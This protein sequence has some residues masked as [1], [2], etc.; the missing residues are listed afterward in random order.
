MKIYG[1]CSVFTNNLLKLI[2]IITMTLDHIGL[3]MMLFLPNHDFYTLALVFRYIGRIAFPI[4]CFLIIEGMMHTRDKINYLLRITIMA[5]FMAICYAIV[6]HFSGYNIMSNIFITFAISILTIILLEQKDWKK[7]LAILPILYSVAG[8]IVGYFEMKNTGNL[9]GWA[10][11][12]PAY[13]RENYELMGTLLIVPSYFLIKY[14]KNSTIETCKDAG[15][16]KEAYMSSPSYKI[17]YNAIY[18][19]VLATVVAIFTALK[20]IDPA[21]DLLGM[22]IQSYMIFAAVFILFY[23]HELKLKSKALSWAFYLYYP[24]HLGIIYGVFYFIFM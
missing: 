24:I 6:G 19:G 8:F 5:V 10:S 20:Y 16:D 2:A 13:L 4:Y 11:Y 12:F 1:K 21:F 18:I 3:A 7:Y 23:N 17:R 22:S 15:I 9:Y 14:Y